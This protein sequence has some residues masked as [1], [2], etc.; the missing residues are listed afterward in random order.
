MPM[1]PFELLDEI[2]LDVGAARAPLAGQADRRLPRA[3]PA[4]EEALKRGWLGKKSGR[5]FYVHEQAKKGRSAGQ[6][7]AQRRAGR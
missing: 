4:V 5:G 3:A 2:G 1:G 7:E 6:D